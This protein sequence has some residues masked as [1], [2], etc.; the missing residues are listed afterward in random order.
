MLNSIGLEN[1][2]IRHFKEEYL[3]FLKKLDTRIVVSIAGATKQEFV[4][5]A[6][7]LAGKYTP[8]AIELNLSCPNV[9]H[10]GV[11]KG[12]LCQ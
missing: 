8:D 1:K 3:P 12:S 9:S 6:E 5:C 7:E 11:K 10:K 2:G 4:K